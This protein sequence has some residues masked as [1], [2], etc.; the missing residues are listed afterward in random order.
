MSAEPLPDSPYRRILFCTDFSEN[1]DHAFTYALD[2][3]P[4]GPTRF[5][6]QF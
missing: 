3:P 1:A 2:G 6:V 4:G 5:R